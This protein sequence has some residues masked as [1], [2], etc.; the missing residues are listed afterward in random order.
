MGKRWNW[1]EGWERCLNYQERDWGNELKLFPEEGR[2]QR[3]GPNHEGQSRV[4]ASSLCGLWWH[5]VVAV[6]ISLCLANVFESLTQH[7]ACSSIIRVHRRQDTGRSNVFGRVEA[8]AA[9]FTSE[10]A[11]LQWALTDLLQMAEKPFP[12]SPP[13]PIFNQPLSSFTFKAMCTRSMDVLFP[14]TIIH[15]R[16]IHIQIKYSFP[17]NW[18]IKRE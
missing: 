11:L 8:E 9:G 13:L 5:G 18:C 12:P 7:P 15:N 16:H 10:A 17:G 1:L 4:F 3:S 2:L 14:P 6:P